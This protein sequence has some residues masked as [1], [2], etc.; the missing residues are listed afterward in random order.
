MGTAWYVW[1]GPKAS[2]S[3]RMSY[4]W[5]C[6]S[7]G[8]CPAWKFSNK[9][10]HSTTACML[11]SF[12]AASWCNRIK[13]QAHVHTYKQSHYRPWQA[14][15]VPGGWGSQILRQSAHEGDKVVSPTHPPPLPPGNIPGTHSVRG[16]VDPRAIVWPQ[17]LRQWKIPVTP[18]GIE[19]ATFRFV[20]QW[21]NQLRH[22]MP[23]TC[24]V[25]IP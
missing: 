10:I 24:T 9:A 1:I 25:A 7:F 22:R 14:L 13:E 18:L 19:P 2:T 16:W 12:D 17:G 6:Q 4:I 3:G 11:T 8:G 20:V 5:S 21:L 23:R 15:R